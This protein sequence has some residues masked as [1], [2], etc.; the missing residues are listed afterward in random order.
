VLIGKASE[1]KDQVKKYGELFEKEIK[2]DGF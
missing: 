1:I 2:A